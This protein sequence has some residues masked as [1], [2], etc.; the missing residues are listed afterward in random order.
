MQAHVHISFKCRKAPRRR[1]GK[2]DRIQMKLPASF[3]RGWFVM[4]AAKDHCHFSPIGIATRPQCRRWDLIFFH[5]MRNAG[6]SANDLPVTIVIRARSGACKF[7]ALSLGLILARRTRLCIFI[8]HCLYDRST[9]FFNGECA[10]SEVTWNKGKGEECLAN[11]AEQRRA[12][13]I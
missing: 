7:R 3:V 8:N 5:E 12:V 13:S 2:C 1:A 6:V 4:A 9:L 10:M 11:S